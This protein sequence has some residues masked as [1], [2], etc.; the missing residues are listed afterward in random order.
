MKFKEKICGRRSVAQHLGAVM[1]ETILQ[2]SRMLDHEGMYVRP[3]RHL[4]FGAR[5][6]RT[7]TVCPPTQPISTR[8]PCAESGAKDTNHHNCPK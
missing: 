8:R 1:T 2:L 3:L 6:E 7:D 5:T 4:A